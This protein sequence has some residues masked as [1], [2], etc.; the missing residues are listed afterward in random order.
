MVALPHVIPLLLLTV[1]FVSTTV[2]VTKPLVDVK[3]SSRTAM[4]ALSHLYHCS[5]SSS[6]C[7]VCASPAIDSTLEVH[8]ATVYLECLFSTKPL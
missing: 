8:C 3:D 7:Q 4:V 5:Q 6:V 2:N 1:G